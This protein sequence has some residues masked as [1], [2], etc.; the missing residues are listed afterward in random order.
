MIASGESHRGSLNRLL[1]TAVLAGA[2]NA[3]RLHISRGDDLN[4]RDG[5]GMTALMLAAS[6]NKGAICALL[7]SAG[8]NRSLTDA[9]GRDA[10]ALAKAAGASD[11]IAILEAAAREAESLDTTGWEVEEDV[12]V[13]IG[14][15]SLAAEQE[16]LHRAISLHQPVD[17]AE[18]WDDFDIFLPEHATPLPGAEEET[19]RRAIRRLLL[20]GY[21]EG[22][23]PDEQVEATCA[24]EDGSRNQE[25][26][27]ILRLTLTEIGSETDERIC[28]E[29][30]LVNVVGPEETA[31]EFV[32]IS[33][34]MEFL[35]DL[36]SGNNDPLR[37]YIKDMRGRKLLTAEEEVSLGRAME[38][39]ISEAIDALASWPEG[40]AAVLAAMEGLRSG[41]IDIENILTDGV[42][43]SSTIAELPIQIRD[44]DFDEEEEGISVAEPTLSNEVRQVLERTTEIARLAEHAGEIGRGEAALREALVAADLPKSLLIKLAVT[45]NSA[46]CEAAATFSRAVGKYASARERMI[47]CNLRLA[48]SIAK[49]YRGMG[50][51]FEDLIQ[52]GNIGLLRAVERFDWRK[53]FRFSTYATWWIRQQVTRAVA[54]KGKTIRTPVHVHESIL[55]ISRESREMESE[56]GRVPTSTELAG[57]LA[58]SPAKILRLIQCLEEPLPI[59]LPDHDGVPPAELVEDVVSC[60]PFETAARDSL[61]KAIAD[62]LA[63]IEPRL[64]DVLSIRFGI[65]S[66]EPRTLEET[67]ALYGVTRERIRQIEAKG[68]RKLG[69]PKRCASLRDFL[70]EGDR[71]EAKARKQVRGPGNTEPGAPVTK[72][73]RTKTDTK[74]A[75]K[76]RKPK[77]KGEATPTAGQVIGKNLDSLLASA[78]KLGIPVNDRRAT[79]GGVFV[80]LTKATDRKS[81]ALAR[82]LFRAGFVRGRGGMGYQE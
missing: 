20:L 66:G 16:A 69:V 15:A 49:R 73:P 31:T 77:G 12:P 26:E 56:L 39:G 38:E 48:L 43:E 29:D 45:T 6:K 18:A 1:V 25:G 27:A 9:E 79:G 36:V 41:E 19:G 30:D 13:P 63:G 33:Q 82:K 35:E 42:L 72:K 51:T 14:D 44:P 68:L 50:L 4:A 10:L 67:G 11:S 17:T 2:E 34:A 8:A 23:V 28:R 65:E 46:P 22:S 71:S 64:A 60:D 53:G 21:R 54:D 37:L 62:A 59:H 74:Y 70:Y 7:L 24:N 76:G 52:E 81:R 61:R 55:R 3:V 5:R 40:V 47:V 32:A 57:R 75:A 58:M 78:Q 80:R